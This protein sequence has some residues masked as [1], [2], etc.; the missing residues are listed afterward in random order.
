M[1][2]ISPSDRA[3]LRSAPPIEEY[4]LAVMPRLTVFKCRLDDADADYGLTSLTYD[5]V[6]EG[7]WNDV[8]VGQTLLVYG[9]WGKYKGKVRI[10]AITADTITVAANYDV[11][12][13]DD[14]VLLV[15]N[16]FEPWSV[17]TAMADTGSGVVYY[18]DSDVAWTDNDTAFPPKANDLGAWAGFLNDDGYVDVQFDAGDSFANAPGA[19]ISSYDRP[20]MD[21]SFVAGNA[22][23][24]Q[25]T[26]RFDQTGFRWITLTVTD[27]NGKTGVHRMPVWTFGG[28]YQPF[29]DFRITRLSR[30]GRDSELQIEA[31]GDDVTQD[32]VY[33][34]AQVVLFTRTTIGGIEVTTDMGSPFAG[35]GHVKL[36][37]WVLKGSVRWDPETGTVAFSVGTLGKVADDMPGY[38]TFIKDVGPAGAQDWHTAVAP[39]VR[40]AIFFLLRWHTN[41]TELAHVEIESVEIIAG[42]KFPK[43]PP[44]RQVENAFLMNKGVFARLGVSRWGSV[45]IRYDP[46]ELS[47]ADRAARATVL[48]LT[49]F[50]WL[51]E[52]NVEKS[53]RPRVSSVFGGGIAYDGGDGTP[54]R[55]RSPGQ[56]GLESGRDLRADNLIIESQSDLNAKLGRLLGAQSSPWRVRPIELF[57]DVFEPALQEYVTLTV[58]AGENP[59]GFSFSTDTRWI[60]RRVDVEPVPGGTPTVRVEVE[61]LAGELESVTVE[62]P[63]EPP[64]PPAPPPPPPPIPPAPVGGTGEVVVIGTEGAGV[65]YSL[66]CRSGNPPTWYQMNGGLS[67]ATRILGL[68]MDPLRPSTHLAVLDKDNTVYAKT[69][70]RGDPTANWTTIL[71]EA[72][73]VAMVP[74]AVGVDFRWVDAFDINGIPHLFVIGDYD[75]DEVSMYTRIL[76]SMDWGASWY[77]F[78]L[79]HCFFGL[80]QHDY[81]RYSATYNWELGLFRADVSGHMVIHEG[82]VVIASRGPGSLGRSSIARRGISGGWWEGCYIPSGN[83]N[84]VCNCSGKIQDGVGGNDPQGGYGPGGMVVSPDGQRVWVANWK[85]HGEI[86]GGEPVRLALYAGGELYQSYHIV[87]SDFGT[88]PG[89]MFEVPQEISYDFLALRIHFVEQE[90]TSDIIE[91]HVFAGDEE[92][93]YGL[94]TISGVRCRTGKAFPALVDGKTILY[95]GRSWITTE[96]AGVGDEEIIYI[97]ERLPQNIG[98]A[99]AP[100]TGNLYTLGAR[101]VSRIHVDSSAD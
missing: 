19:S 42:R 17:P 28:G 66:D 82:S 72:Q 54:Y 34:G 75:M 44:F 57:Y 92:A 50:D 76:Y 8:V 86:E 90:Q 61:W 69:N 67:D 14:E 47:A 53:H 20:A 80:W 10:R 56:V 13:S 99:W 16:V 7:S 23:S 5:E 71:T 52:L 37:G 63:D 1:P 41:L 32:D 70:W 84:P 65:C 58:S 68:A 91:T 59:R 29:R 51:T 83:T 27:S 38:P 26:I 22:G 30:T 33:E 18:K 11:E 43:A 64:S 60:V 2:A 100:K 87:Q 62:I 95:A 12:W 45:H 15:V 36:V 9:I 81:C 98:S 25:A 78:S 77:V 21:G 48:D 49:S 85:V 4:Y 96:Q 97:S 35:R 39:T 88:Y 101:G 3:L 40:S 94:G 31:F 6:L 46:Q 74:G 93:L 73:A 24:Q 79:V 89:M 55:A